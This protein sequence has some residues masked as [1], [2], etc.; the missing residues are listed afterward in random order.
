MDGPGLPDSPADPGLEERLAGVEHALRAMATRLDHL[1]GSVADTVAAEG[2][3]LAQELRH[4]LS[5]LARLI[6]KDLGRLGKL[7]ERDRRDVLEALAARGEILVASTPA[8]PAAVAG[9]ETSG[10]PSPGAEPG[11]GT[12]GGGRS[13]VTAAGAG[14]EGS[15]GAVGDRGPTGT[16]RARDDLR[17]RSGVGEDLG[18][19]RVDDARVDDDR[20]SD[21]GVDDDRVGDDRRSDA[22]VDDDR[23]DDDR[24]A[25]DRGA[26]DRGAGDRAAGDGVGGGGRATEPPGVAAGDHE[27]PKG[28]RGRFRGRRS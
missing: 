5:E 3:A 6:V 20:R 13:P 18:P 1:E 24:A 19:D 12:G 7:V 14:D 22:G 8:T 21:A 15:G 9:G 23:V 28:R 25:G 27:R 11:S 16:E 17:T 10:P 2:Q 4:T 26:G